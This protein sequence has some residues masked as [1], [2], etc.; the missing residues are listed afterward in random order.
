MAP[1][2]G[3][4]TRAGLYGAL[5]AQFVEVR[6]GA[7]QVNHSIGNKVVSDAADRAMALLKANLDCANFLAGTSG[8]DPVRTL[9]RLMKEG[10]ILIKD[11]GVAKVFE[12]GSYQVVDA[13]SVLGGPI[14][15]NSSGAFFHPTWVDRERGGPYHLHLAL[16][17]WTNKTN[18]T[19]HQYRE[20]VILHELGHVMGGIPEDADDADMSQRNI[21]AVLKNCF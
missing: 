1:L 8:L 18:L 17:N 9:D 19:A 2:L 5:G 6:G 12:D 13:V 3:A 16:W 21:E 14:T 7:S 4:H 10:Q 20:V 11:L 15:I